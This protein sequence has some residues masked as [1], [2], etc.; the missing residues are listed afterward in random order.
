MTVYT[1][2]FGPYDTLKEPLVIT[3]GWRYVC[4]TDQDFKSNVWEIVKTF[5][6]DDI[7]KTARL[8]KITAFK[9][10]PSYFSIYV[11]GS[12]QINCDLMEWSMPN[13]RQ[14]T[15]IK[16]PWRNCVYEEAETC[17]K[18]G[19]GEPDKIRAQVENYKISGLPEGNGLISS[20]ILMRKKT[21]EVVEFCETW[22]KQVEKFSN[23]DQLAFAFTDFIY[24]ELHKSIEYDYLHRDEFVFQKH[25]QRQIV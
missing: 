15:T 6:N 25:L 5:P 2:I 12:F 10:L 9:L 1:V 14:F 21:P 13:N 17:L 3:P 4:F 22:W 7:V 19:K 11:D 20:G 23:R 18:M 24:P 16:H 8:Y